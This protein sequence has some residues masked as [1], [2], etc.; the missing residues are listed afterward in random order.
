MNPFSRSRANDAFEAPKDGGY[1]VVDPYGNV[2]SW[3]S[4]KA[5]AKAEAKR[6]NKAKDAADKNS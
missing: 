6:L 3:H 2:S 1:P 5:D 4:T